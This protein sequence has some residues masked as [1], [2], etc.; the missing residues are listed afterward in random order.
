MQYVLEIDE[1]LINEQI[2]NILNQAVDKEINSKYGRA[3]VDGIVKET[4]KELIY[5]R[6]E[7]IIERVVNRATQEIVR[8]GIPKLLERMGNN[9]NA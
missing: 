6:K 1:G 5:T 3:P 7:E 9:E 8:K 4:V 2:R